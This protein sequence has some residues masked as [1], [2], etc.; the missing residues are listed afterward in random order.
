MDTNRK[1]LE[2]LALLLE[3]QETRKRYRKLDYMFPLTGKYAR[4]YYPKHVEFFAAGKEYPQRCIVGANRVGK[5]ETCHTELAYHI[6][7]LYRDWWPGKVF[8]KPVNVLCLGVT[9]DS[10]RD[11]SQFKLLGNRY[12]EGTGLIPLSHINEEKIS[13]KPGTPNARAE[14]YIKHVDSSGREDGYSK[15][16]FKSYISGPE[17]F[18][19]TEYDIILMDEE[20]PSDVYSE[21]LMRTAT[22]KGIIICCFTPL[23]GISEVFLSFVPDLKPP[24]N[25]VVNKYRYT[26]VITWDDMPPHLGEEEKAN[27]KSG[28]LPHEV[29]A[30]TT[31]IPMV[32]AG[33]VYQVNPDD[34]LVDSFTIPPK[35]ERAYGM[36]VG[37]NKTAAI[38]AAQDPNSKIW[39]LYRE[40]YRGHAE[41][42]SHAA[43][44]KGNE[45]WLCGAIDPASRG[46][47]QRDGKQ[48]IEEYRLHGLTLIPAD[49]TVEA[50]ILKCYQMLANG[51]VKVF[52]TLTNFQDE[53]RLYRRKEDGQIIK[54][55]D[56]LMDAWRYMMMT[57]VHYTQSTPQSEY[58]TDD[59]RFRRHF[60]YNDSR[61]PDTGY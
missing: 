46:R 11:V 17:V 51:A 57:G 48:L 58:E 14:A 44:I 36:D 28:L 33:A 29:G 6:T 54:Q 16:Q 1:E 12:S 61:D 7:G 27:I 32:G 10:V 20:P 55:K 41:P 24:E 4:Q 38:W 31:G 35:W 56:H 37:W 23:N 45:P 3:E 19:G 39:Y 22:T 43:G 21:A 60:D 5:S 15:V 50:G 2:Q 30:R 9:H 40:Y 42:V 59:E 18:M 26:Q 47:G 53:I 49:N 52:R 25:G 34:F 13:S 8:N